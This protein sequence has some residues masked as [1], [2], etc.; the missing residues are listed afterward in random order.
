VVKY[1][2]GSLALTYMRQAQC[3]SGVLVNLV[4][5]S[6]IEPIFRAERLQGC[7]FEFLQGGM[8]K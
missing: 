8:T 2:I 7:N 3:E 4:A 1:I 5:S 6:L